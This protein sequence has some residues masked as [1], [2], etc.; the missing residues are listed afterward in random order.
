MGI[1][2][3]AI[4]PL[5]FL[6]ILYIGI[7]ASRSVQSSSDFALAR[8][9]LPFPMLLGTMIGTAIGAAST[10]GRAGKAY[11]VGILISI[12]GVAYGFG[13]LAFYWFLP[14]LRR[15]G[16]WSV[17]E[18]LGTRYGGV[19]R[20]V[21]AITIL[22][23]LIG[24]FGSQ[25]IALA[26]TASVMLKGTGVSFAMA[27]I[28]G[29]VVMTAYTFMGGMK[30]VATADMIQVVLI[31]FLIGLCLPVI[32]VWNLGGISQAIA[33][34][35]PHDGQWLGGMT[36]TY[37]ISLFLI[38]V[39]V[40]LIDASLWQKAGAARTLHDVRR[41][42][43]ITAL[44]FMIWGVL[45]ASM[46]A[47]AKVLIPSLIASGHA[48]DLTLPM[49][50][51]ELVPTILKG[52]TFAALMA[53]M[54]STAATALLVAGTMSGYEILRGVQPGATDRAVLITMR[55]TIA[56]MGVIGV[57]IA[58]NVQ[59]VFD[60]LL[61]AM[62]VYVSGLFFPTMAALFWK[63]ATRAGAYA[64]SIGG[65]VTVVALYAMKIA[66]VLP[67]ILEPIIGGLLVSATLLYIVSIAS[68]RW[69]TSTPPLINKPQTETGP[70]G[71]RN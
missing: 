43:L 63:G 53:V 6:A 3:L 54:I 52:L 55:G 20:I 16:F 71:I 17:P 39:P 2:D 5:Y 41:A 7:R 19:F 46:G 33:A 64:G 4:V 32:L 68:A 18:A 48:A 22:L 15:T 34:A 65:S 44:L 8:D 69:S 9:G 47:F 10:M 70:T 35:T 49:L 12:S 40:V 50:V 60:L 51:L 56:A 62:A 57:I 29:A 61:L 23:G 45:T 31:L 36:L 42:A 24:L 27:V 38:D 28:L 14:K 58:L 66:G 67:P 59:G 25:L 13:L 11:E 26:L 21:A 1:V 37:L 30:S